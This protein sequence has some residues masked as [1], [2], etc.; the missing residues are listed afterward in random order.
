MPDAEV[1]RPEAQL[2]GTLLHGGGWK[3]LESQAVDGILSL[4][5][6]RRPP[7]SLRCATTMA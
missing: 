3:H 6:L 4:G 7:A 1:G 2:N 5:R